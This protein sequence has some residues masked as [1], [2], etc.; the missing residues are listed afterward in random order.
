MSSRPGVQHCVKCARG[1]LKGLRGRCEWAARRCTHRGNWGGGGIVAERAPT[2]KQK[3]ARLPVA[4]A[5]R[6]VAVEAPPVR[7]DDRV[8]VDLGGRPARALVVRKVPHVVGAAGAVPV[9]VRRLDPLQ[10]L[11]RHHDG[12]ADARPRVDIPPGVVRPA[13]GGGAEEVRG[14]KRL[15]VF[16]FYFLSSLSLSL[17]LYLHLF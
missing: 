14:K 3:R 12:V 16:L 13:F 2:S 10:E 9:G 5:A 11:L 1:G 17:S 4:R 7:Q 8:R 15:W 6:V